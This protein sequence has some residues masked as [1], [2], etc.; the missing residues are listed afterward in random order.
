MNLPV[1]GL[2]HRKGDCFSCCWPSA[3]SLVIMKLM[4]TN[5]QKVETP[6][7]ESEQKEQTSKDKE[8]KVYSDKGDDKKKKKALTIVVG[9]TGKIDSVIAAYLLKKQGHRCIGVAV[10]NYEK[11]M[12][13]L[14]NPEVPPEKVEEK[15]LTVYGH[16]HIEDVSR[17]KKICDQLDIPFYA[18]NAAREFSEK[19]MGQTIGSR[20]SGEQFS[21]CVFC[22]KMLVEVL[23]EKAK[24]LGADR[25]ATGHYAKVN[26][27]NGLYQIIMANEIASDQSFLLS[28]LSQETLAML[29]L[30][31][32]EMRKVD[33]SKIAQSLGLEFV[34][35]ASER[36]TCF[37]TDSKLPDLVEWVS[38]EDLRKKG[39]ILN[40]S[41][42]VF[43]SDHSGIH[44]FYLGQKNFLGGDDKSKA[45]KGEDEVV[46]IDPVSGHVYV[47][48]AS[49]VECQYCVLGDFFAN[50]FDMSGPFEAYARF[51][52][53]QEMLA[54]TVY[55]KNNNTLVLAF[56]KPYNGVVS[57]GRGLTIYNRQG[58]GGKVIG[59]G[60]V[61]N[62]G[63][64]NNLETLYENMEQSDQELLG[65]K[66]RAIEEST[67][68]HF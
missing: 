11:I 6:P 40:Y 12:G 21:P 19:I 47:G 16:C 50:P 41:N 42:D 17:V 36:H 55:P 59:Q 25:V 38:S 14:R 46:D 5:S 57:A 28:R 53:G 8:M 32:S 64:F 20:L 13:K 4:S 9:M 63:P 61:L 66:Q 30:P 68:L 60:T 37:V 1:F 15:D 24:K 10:V 31:L 52:F 62:Y 54:C 51:G 26:H 7:V 58:A 48:P 49:K 22:H 3:L 34:P 56:T 33:T 27:S 18:T 67:K 45:Q 43:V 65:R 2:G 39:Q 35:S 29:D 23:I 44:H